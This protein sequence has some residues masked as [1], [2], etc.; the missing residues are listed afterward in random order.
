MS[1]NDVIIQAVVAVD[2]NA[3]I[4]QKIDPGKEVLGHLTE[5]FVYFARSGN[6]N[7]FFK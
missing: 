7:G 2:N 1:K 5:K 6:G 4:G 3:P